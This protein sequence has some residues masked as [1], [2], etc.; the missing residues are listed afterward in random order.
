MDPRRRKTRSTFFDFLLGRKNT[1]TPQPKLFRTGY[2]M[3]DGQV[4]EFSTADADT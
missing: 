4:V 2:G 1:V 3:K